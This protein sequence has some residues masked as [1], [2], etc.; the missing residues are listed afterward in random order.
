MP[1]LFAIMASYTSRGI[2]PLLR[3]PN[4]TR[5]G[6]ESYFTQDR[7]LSPRDPLLPFLVG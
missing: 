3:A 6:Q 1:I 4:S 7:C 5:M 2:S